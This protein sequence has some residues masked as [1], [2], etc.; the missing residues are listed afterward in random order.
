MHFIFARAL[1]CVC[2]MLMYLCVNVRAQCCKESQILFPTRDIHASKLL[3]YSY[4]KFATQFIILVYRGLN[5]TF[6]FTTINYSST[7]L[8]TFPKTFIISITHY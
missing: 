6:V 4:Y 7:F 3:L 8:S 1:V 2:N 5:I